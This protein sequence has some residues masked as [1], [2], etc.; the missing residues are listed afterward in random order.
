MA[1][2]TLSAA[3]WNSDNRSGAVVADQKDIVITR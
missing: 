1:Y 2:E 3:R